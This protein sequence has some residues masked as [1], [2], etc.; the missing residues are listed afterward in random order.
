MVCHVYNFRRLKLLELLLGLAEVAST[1]HVEADRLNG[2]TERELR[3]TLERGRH[4]PTVTWSP[5]TTSRKAGE[6]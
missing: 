5:K 3:Q 2:H 4:W 1:D 6:M